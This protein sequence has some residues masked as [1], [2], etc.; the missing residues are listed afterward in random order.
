MESTPLPWAVADF[1]RSPGTLLLQENSAWN[2]VDVTDRRWQASPS[3]WP[4][5]TASHGPD[6]C[7]ASQNYTVKDIHWTMPKGGTRK[8]GR[9]KSY[10]KVGENITNSN[11]RAETS[12]K[13]LYGKSGRLCNQHWFPR[14]FQ[15]LKQHLLA[16]SIWHVKV[17]SFRWL[18]Q[19]KFQIQN[20]PM[21]WSLK[22]WQKTPLWRSKKVCHS[23]DL[24]MGT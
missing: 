10:Q 23:C 2:G 20:K 12:R 4:L 15:A 7:T 17:A 21:L 16:E 24:G 1:P 13:P 18:L 3:F 14:F 5:L 8:K 22:F 19:S 9:N 11:P 6:W